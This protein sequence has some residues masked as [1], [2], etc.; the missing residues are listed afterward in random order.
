MLYSI[1]NFC[2]KSSLLL[3]VFFIS[4][5]AVSETRPPVL[6]FSDLINGPD[7][8]I[9]D[10]LGSGAIVTVWGFH[11]GAS[12]LSSTL[13]FC[14]SASVCREGHIYYWKNA[15]GLLPSGPA[16]LY[17]SHGMQEI[18]FSIPDS[19][20]G[21]GIIKINTSSGSST[22]PFTIRPGQIFHITSTGDDSTGDGSY[23][24]PW[25]TIDRADNSNTGVPSGSTIYIHNV[26]T[27]TIDQTSKF[28]IYS[29]GNGSK[30]SL[31]AQYSYV[32]Y[33]NTH[34]EI[35]AANGALGYNG[36]NPVRGLVESKLSFYIAE[37]DEDADHQP[38]NSREQFSFG[39]YGSADGRI[40]GNFITDH[41]P[42][43]I[44][45]GCPDA[46]QGAIVSGVGSGDKA[47]NLK[48]FGNEIKEYGCD[49]TNR[50]HHTTYFTIR[51]GESN[52]QLVSPEIGWNY[53]KDNL[54]QGGIHYFD[55]NLNGVN[56]GDFTGIFK[57]HDNVIVNQAGPALE[58]YAKCPTTTK[59]EYYNNIA[60]NSGLKS[61]FGPTHTDGTLYEAV[62]IGQA[63]G[64]DAS[65]AELNFYNNVFYKWN[66][67]DQTGQLN[68]CIGFHAIEATIT[69]KWTDN[70]CL[71][72]KDKPFITSDYQGKLLES[73]ITG[74][75]NVWFSSANTNNN[76][77]PPSWDSTKIFSDPKLLWS[78]SK[79]LVRP[80]SPIIGKSSSTL[81]HDIYGNS[82]GVSSEVGAVSY[83]MI[84]KP[85]HNL[86]IQ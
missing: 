28:G 15:D 37:A 51:G 14:D 48:V 21:L 58:N 6:S 31:E 80:D 11:L 86:K 25:K 47:S 66:D 55:E 43:D 56:C 30:S 29:N 77:I 44:N 64:S 65:H 49:G 81:S 22:L 40:I 74:E 10:G 32:A 75:G 60:I 82:R 26:L 67:M 78:A 35:V 27:G 41:Y 5:V 70:I 24:N 68:S 50:Q 62:M 76:S 63:G 20:A 42:L 72:D 13:E 83:K 8:G 46:Q 19:E 57:I 85:P 53:L 38:I 18:A 17:E 59:F 16:N 71:T 23:N 4:T 79:L 84:P 7:T 36:G 12:K 33:P 9:G 1:L 2:K 52:P 61:A 3:T 73:A 69:I 34:P 39:I 54:A 45:G